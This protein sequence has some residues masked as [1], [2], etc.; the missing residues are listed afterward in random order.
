MSLRE[1]QKMQ[2]REH[3]IA[4]AGQLFG[5]KGFQQTSIDDITGA[6]GMSRATLYAHFDGKDLLLTAIVERMW[7]EAQEFWDAFGAMPDWSRGTIL[8]WVRDFARA[9][10]RDAPRNQA[11]VVASPGLFWGNADAAHWHRRQREA[12]R[13][14]AGLWSGFTEAEAKMRAAMIVDVVEGQF[15]NYFYEHETALELEVFIGYVADAVRDLL[16]AS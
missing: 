10:E 4:V 5:E 2:T 13:A 15:A 6:A 16:G 3:L 7:E 11:A 9:W 12:V 14:N 8:S 1:R